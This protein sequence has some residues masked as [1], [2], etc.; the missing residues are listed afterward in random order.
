MNSKKKKD[1]FE[2]AQQVVEGIKRNRLCLG[3]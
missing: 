1:K 3:F 2:G